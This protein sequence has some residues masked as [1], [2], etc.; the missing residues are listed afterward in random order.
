[1]M[2][3]FAKPVNGLTFFAKRS[4]TDVKQD[5]SY[6]PA[7]MKNNQLCQNISRKRNLHR[8]TYLGKCKDTLFQNQPSKGV[9]KIFS[10][11]TG[12]QLY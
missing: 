9:L 2:E 1:M 10:K 3:L 7:F 6:T 5:L 11:F 8:S 12:K 4:I